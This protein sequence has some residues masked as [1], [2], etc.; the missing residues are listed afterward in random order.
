[1]WETN[2]Y[3]MKSL[4]ILD[5]GVKTAVAVAGGSLCQQT[6]KQKGHGACDEFWWDGKKVTSA[7][8]LEASRPRVEPL[9][10]LHTEARSVVE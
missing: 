10:R 5:S 8:S 6:A 3:V 1:M 2:I 4:G 9:L 7:R